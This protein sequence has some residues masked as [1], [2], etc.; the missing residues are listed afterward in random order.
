MRTRRLA[1]N[2]LAGSSFEN[3]FVQ[4]ESTSWLWGSAKAAEPPKAS[5][6]RLFGLSLANTT[7]PGAVDD[8]LQAARARRKT[9]VVF[10][11]A[12]VVNTAAVDPSYQHVLTAADYC[13]ADGSGMA[14]AAKLAGTPFVANT[15]GTDL[16]PLLC[17]EAAANG[18]KVFLLG[19]AEGISER[20]AETIRRAGHGAAIAGTR[21]GFFKPGST[22]E[23]EA[24]EAINAS[25]A[26]ILLVGLGVPLQDTWI[27]ANASRI[28]A[29]V[30]AGVGGLFDF[31]AGT[32]TRAPV[33]L[34]AFGM[35]WM[36]RLMQEPGRLWRRYLLGN[37]VFLARAVGARI[38]A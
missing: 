15:N 3:L 26:D 27:A 23:T 1:G 35:E 17:A 16:F 25:G 11:N 2:D 13:L 37:A 6:L 4:A 12:H 10:V 32:V 21:H 36:W 22:G 30:M 20:A 38:A 34:R 14:I 19:G 8:L 28:D 33:G 5:R 18:L 7:L 9:Q 24:I 31:F 29:P